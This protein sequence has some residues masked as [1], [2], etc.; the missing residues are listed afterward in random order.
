MKNMQQQKNTNDTHLLTLTHTTKHQHP[1]LPYIAHFMRSIH[2]YSLQMEISLTS[3]SEPCGWRAR[4]RTFSNDSIKNSRIDC[5][6][7][8][9]WA[10]KYKDQ[11]D[12]VATSCHTCV[13]QCVFLCHSLRILFSFDFSNLKFCWASHQTNNCV[14][15]RDRCGC[16][17][18]TEKCN[19]YTHV[20]HLIFASST[21]VFV[22]TLARLNIFYHSWTVLFR[23]Q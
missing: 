23:A 16:E 20:K 7:I 8:S 5:N 1:I 19:R 3:E 14:Q 9:R 2:I 6:W 15:T 18:V 10:L 12:S 11:F 21:A 13:R 17:A 4:A 22:P